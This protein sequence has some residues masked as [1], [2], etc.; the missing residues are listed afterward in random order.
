MP[1]TAA[2]QRM[3]CGSRAVIRSRS[4]RARDWFSF[5]VFV[6]SPRAGRRTAGSR[7]PGRATNITAYVGV[8]STSCSRRYASRNRRRPRFRSTA[9]PT[10][11]LTAN[12]TRRP[13]L[14]WLPQHHEARPLVPIALLEQRLDFSRPAEADR[15]AAAKAYRKEY[16]FPRLDGQSLASFCATPLE[17]LPPALRLHPLAKPMRLAAAA[18]IRLKGPLHGELSPPLGRRTSVVY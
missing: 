8:Q 7:T 9:P 2:T 11:R 6:A 10:R 13:S 17:H 1:R 16:V 15:S 18:S 12:P 14:Q 5:R 4:S 3:F